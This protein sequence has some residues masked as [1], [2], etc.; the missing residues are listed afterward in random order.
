M[1][2]NVY[3]MIPLG[4]SS[5]SVIATPSDCHLTNTLVPSGE[6]KVQS[7]GFASL[8]CSWPSI[9]F[10]V[11]HI[12]S[13]SIVFSELKS[14]DM[15]TYNGRPGEGLN[16]DAFCVNGGRCKAHATENQG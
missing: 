2:Q 7:I 5:T 12:F 13:F 15:C 16:K 6:L 11:A 14:T 3:Q 8:C 10:R 4:V 9:C 1:V